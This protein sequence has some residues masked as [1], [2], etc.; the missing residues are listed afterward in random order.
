MISQNLVCNEDT[1]KMGGEHHL[2]FHQNSN[3]PCNYIHDEE[4]TQKMTISEADL[5]VWPKIKKE[6]VWFIKLCYCH[7]SDTNNKNTISKYLSRVLSWDNPKKICLYWSCRDDDNIVGYMCHDISKLLIL[8]YPGKLCACYDRCKYYKEH[9]NQNW[10]MCTLEYA[11]YETIPPFLIYKVRDLCV[12]FKNINLNVDNYINGQT[13]FAS[14]YLTKIITPHYHFDLYYALE[15]NLQ[16]PWKI[17]I[18][19][20]YLPFEIV[21]SICK[22]I[23]Y[24]YR[25]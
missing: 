2:S 19:M 1:N 22:Y 14:K 5:I 16:I 17:N 24:I 7:I 10:D 8:A 6:I 13:I 9:T 21:D 18:L 4:Q 23:Y 11:K 3:P 12:N 15:K 20:K 25:R